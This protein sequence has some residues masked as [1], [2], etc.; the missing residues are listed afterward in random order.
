M[1][2]AICTNAFHESDRIVKMKNI[3]SISVITLT[4]NSEEYLK[5]CLDSIFLARKNLDSQTIFEHI[6][7][8]GGSTDR[9][10]EIV[11]SHPLNS[12]LLSSPVKGLYPS[13]DYAINKA[14]NKYIFYVHS[15]DFVSENFFRLLSNY[16]AK[17]FSQD[18][19][20]SKRIIYPCSDIAFVNRKS[21]IL[22]WR[23]QPLVI[24]KLQNYANLVFHPNCLFNRNIEL[25]FP[26]CKPDSN[27]DNSHN[28]LD[29][30][31]INTLMKNNIGFKRIPGAFYYFRIH[32]GSTTVK[33]Q[34]SKFL[35]SK[36]IIEFKVNPVK[37]LSKLYLYCHENRKSKRLFKR[38]F[39]NQHSWKL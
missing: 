17:L 14:K 19:K 28:D 18:F 3:I 37:L 24:P 12:V 15:D 26:Y 29:W 9:T 4:Y 23:R 10:K 38:L 35:S 5:E 6:V 22:W 1:K 16:S 27:I 2:L 39:L 33:S 20:S 8:D 11:V 36:S 30:I 25:M 13:L 21:K 7:C 32:P 34:A 31:H